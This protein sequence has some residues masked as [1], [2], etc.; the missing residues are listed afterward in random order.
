MNKI[1]KMFFLG[2][3]LCLITGCSE[4]YED[5]SFN[6]E[7]EMIVNESYTYSCNY[8]NDDIDIVYDNTYLKFENQS[9][10]ALKEGTTKVNI[11]LKEDEKVN[12]EVTINIK[13][14]T[15][16]FEI[17]YVIDEET[18]L[19]N[20]KVIANRGEN[21]TLDIP[22]KEGYEFAGWSVSEDL[23]NPVLTIIVDKD[24]T[25]YPKW[26][27]IA[28]YSD[29]IYHLNNGSISGEYNLQYEEG[30]EYL[31]PI[32]QREGY[33]FAGWYQEA[34][35]TDNSIEKINDT[36]TGQKEVYAYWNRIAIDDKGDAIIDKVIFIIGDGM[37]FNQIELARLLNPDHEFAFDKI[38]NK[39]EVKTRSFDSDITD[40]AAAAT[41]F[42]TAHKTNRGTLGLDENKNKLENIIEFLQKRGFSAGIVTSKGLNDATPAGF[43]SHVNNRYDDEIE[44]IT[45]QIN[46]DIDLMFGGNYLDFSKQRTLINDNGYYLAL[47]KDNMTS[48]H[49]KKIMGMFAASDMKS[50]VSGKPN[51]TD[52]AYYSIDFLD[53][54][55]DN[56]FLMIEEGMIDYYCGQGVS[57]D[58]A[59]RVLD[60][61]NTLKY[62]LEYATKDERTLVIVTADHETGGLI[63]GEGEPNSSWY[64]S[65][66]KYHTG[67]NVPLYAF[68]P[69]SEYFNNKV[70]DNTEVIPYIASLLGYEFPA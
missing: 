15:V 24:L 61:D 22:S 31:L 28:T 37:G 30:K 1:I 54:L 55:N 47:T 64:T 27:K 46:S 45:Q 49:G 7:K 23:S 12:L 19:E 20:T 65:D 40:S 60:V 42:A 35:Y 57:L 14:E 51:F 18:T 43:S 32:P 66:G 41:A 9:V 58:V 16:T 69:G 17:T 13:E 63:I 5:I 50:Y 11:K 33:T 25:L 6:I 39:G 70:L 59:R 26:E 67:V 29:I 34:G 52:M 62:A 8:D 3:L 21:K 10:T 44:I 4:P 53:K 48:F 56:F 36:D 38:V 68:G 2:L